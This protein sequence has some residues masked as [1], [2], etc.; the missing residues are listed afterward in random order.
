MIFVVTEILKVDLY[1]DLNGSVTARMTVVSRTI[2]VVTEDGVT[3]CGTTVNFHVFSNM[4][5]PN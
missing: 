4:N 3:L 1:L 2:S 5:H